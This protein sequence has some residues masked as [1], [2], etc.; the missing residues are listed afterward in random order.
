MRQ[1]DNITIERAETSYGGPDYLKTTA[2]FGVPPK[3]LI[4]LFSWEK[5]HHT[6]TAI[7]PFFESC[8]I[9][10]NVSSH[11]R[12][13]LKTTKRP[14]VFPKRRFFMS[15][16]ESFQQSPF[17]I[18]LHSSWHG[19]VKNIDKECNRDSF[20]RH[21]KETETLNSANTITITVPKKTIISSL[22]TVNIAAN[23][24]KQNELKDTNN[25]I[26]AFQDFIAWFIDDGKGY[27]ILYLITLSF[28]N[29]LKLLR[30]N[31]SRY[32]N[33]CGSWIGYPEVSILSR[34]E[35]FSINCT[36]LTSGGP[37]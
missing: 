32:S 36:P 19:Y 21:S 37:F 34:L 15:M 24:I 11:C 9:H 33:A 10:M 17:V 1:S 35:A 18:N 3:K 5:F 14:L 16:M 26:H 23:S 25:Y 30:R 8:S 28:L 6:Q 2:Q 7:D 22:L 29:A 12:V 13:I 27:N 4:Q 31:P 20:E